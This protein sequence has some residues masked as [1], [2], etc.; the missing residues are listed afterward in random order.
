MV[1][2]EIYVVE[3]NPGQ[4]V[5]PITISTS[6]MMFKTGVV[7]KLIKYTFDFKLGQNYKLIL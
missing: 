6:N 2:D 4:D 7:D 5:K 3:N 1:S